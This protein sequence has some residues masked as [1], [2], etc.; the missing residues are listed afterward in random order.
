MSSHDIVDR[1]W[2][3]LLRASSSRDKIVRLVWMG[4]QIWTR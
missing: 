3:V 4:D 2:L 1:D